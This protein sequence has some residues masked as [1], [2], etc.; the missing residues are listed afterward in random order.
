MPHRSL[1]E[2]ILRNVRD[3]PLHFLWAG[4]S[5]F[6]P[7]ATYHWIGGWLPVA[8]VFCLGWASITWI[9][10]REIGQFPPHDWWDAWL[11]WSMY[12]AGGV[13]GMV[14]GLLLNV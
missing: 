3:Q 5:T 11:D 14:F 1:K 2:N 7:W 4:S 12:A 6:L 8:L 13:T 10:L 9:V